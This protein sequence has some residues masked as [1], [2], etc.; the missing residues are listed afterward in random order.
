MSVW[1]EVIETSIYN[2]PFTHET[3]KVT[4][5]TFSSD[6]CLVSHRVNDEMYYTQCKNKQIKFQNHYM[7]HLALHKLRA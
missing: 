4:E 7:Y 1:T 6:R 2:L 5:D 3:A